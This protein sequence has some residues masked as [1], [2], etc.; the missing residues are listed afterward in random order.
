MS[1]HA[2]QPVRNPRVYVAVDGRT[3]W[4]EV[5]ATFAAYT[6]AKSGQVVYAAGGPRT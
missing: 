6:D 5:A 4:R 1:W 2:L 3:S